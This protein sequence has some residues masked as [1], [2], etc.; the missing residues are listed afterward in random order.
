MF[1][2]L[3]EGL[4]FSPLQTDPSCFRNVEVDINVFIRV[5]GGLLFGPCIE[6][7]R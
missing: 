4:I 6:I 7:Q 3:G 1:A 2:T 5:D